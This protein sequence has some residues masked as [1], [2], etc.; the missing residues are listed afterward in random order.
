MKAVRM[1]KLPE[2]RGKQEKPQPKR[3]QKPL[4][5]KGSYYTFRPFQTWKTLI[6]AMAVLGVLSVV[7]GSHA[8]FGGVSE[9][10]DWDRSSFYLA[11]PYAVEAMSVYINEDDRPVV[12]WKVDKYDPTLDLGSGYRTMTLNGTTVNDFVRMPKMG[13]NTD[14]VYMSVEGE[15]HYSPDELENLS[16]YEFD[17]TAEKDDEVHAW[18]FGDYLSGDHDQADPATLQRVYK[19][20]NPDEYPDYQVTDGGFDQSDH[21]VTYTV[22][23]R[24]RHDDTDSYYLYTEAQILFKKD[25]EVV[26]ADIVDVES[27]PEENP[28][29]AKTFTRTYTPSYSIPEY[30][31]VELKSLS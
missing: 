6:I 17:L 7:S 23:R 11:D 12:L 27:D 30:D 21:T 25:G 8:S 3:R 4:R 26:F 14:T 2:D 20:Q 24:Y 1:P 5:R 31:S 15:A 13:P 9:I 16:P 22:A 19:A 28:S 29:E 18:R 10:D